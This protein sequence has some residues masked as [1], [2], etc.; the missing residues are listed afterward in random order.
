MRELFSTGVQ[1]VINVDSTDQDVEFLK[2]KSMA[3]RSVVFKISVNNER[4]KFSPPGGY[5]L[6]SPGFTRKEKL[7]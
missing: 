1:T 6:T 4:S 5:G 7:S 2:K 3:P